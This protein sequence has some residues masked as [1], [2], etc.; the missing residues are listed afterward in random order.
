M[1]CGYLCECMQ[2]FWVSCYWKF[3]YPCGMEWCTWHFAYPCGIKW[4]KKWR[5]RY[6]CGIKWCKGS[7]PYPCGI[8]YCKGRMWY[9]C[10]KAFPV[11]MYCYD[12]AQYHKNCTVV[13]GKVYICCEGKEY[14]WTERCFGWH[15]D[16]RLYTTPTTKCTY[17]KLKEHGS[18]LEGMNHSLPPGGTVPVGG[19][20]NSPLSG[21][22]VLHKLDDS[23][24]ITCAKCNAPIRTSSCYSC[25]RKIR[26]Y[27][28]PV[29][30]TKVKNPEY[31]SKPK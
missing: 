8:I 25:R 30:G 26:E 7:L 18:C 29:C 22:R 24:N 5:I 11:P 20:P 15:D 31:E 10:R 19:D 23:W 27:K 1:P 21:G 12:V 16:W 13:Y 28:C 2:D 4:C 6:P 9:P 17:E 3:S 14:E